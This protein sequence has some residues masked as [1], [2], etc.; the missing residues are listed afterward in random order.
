MER[1]E[2]TCILHNFL[3]FPSFPLSSCNPVRLKIKESVPPSTYDPCLTTR[4]LLSSPSSRILPNRRHS[5]FLSFYSSTSSQASLASSLLLSLLKNR[6]AAPPLLIA[7]DYVKKRLVFF[8]CSAG[9]KNCRESLV[10][11]HLH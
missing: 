5:S 6:N 11:L 1:S 9:Q 7:N 10:S 8:P 2:Y 4:F 3:H